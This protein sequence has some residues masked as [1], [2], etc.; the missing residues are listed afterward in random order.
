MP[1]VQSIRTQTIIFRVQQS[2]AIAYT[3]EGLLLN[4]LS[5]V[6]ITAVCMV[7][8]LLASVRSAV[9]FDNND[10]NKYNPSRHGLAHG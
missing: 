2:S 9:D 7:N 10:I 6:Y 1:Q 5:R 4:Q 8:A 3:N